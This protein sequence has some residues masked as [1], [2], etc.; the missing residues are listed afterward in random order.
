MDSPTEIS[1]FMLRE[2]DEESNGKRY[3]IRVALHH[4]GTE[5]TASK[6]TDAVKKIMKQEKAAMGELPNF[7]YGTYTFLACYMPQASG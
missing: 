2:F 1:N 6:Y 7:D 5:A 3:K 4:P